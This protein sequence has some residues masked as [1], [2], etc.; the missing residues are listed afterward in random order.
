[1]QKNIETK[2]ILDPGLEAVGMAE[3]FD[4]EEASGSLR[5]YCPS[6]RDTR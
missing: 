3:T 1:M 4:V 5:L 2:E 6:W